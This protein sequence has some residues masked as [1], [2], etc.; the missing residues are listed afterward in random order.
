[1]DNLSTPAERPSEVAEKGK[2]GKKS[3]LSGGFF[4]EEIFRTALNPGFQPGGAEPDRKRINEQL[5]LN[6][7]S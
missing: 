5:P 4:P 7:G 3:S 1:M 2:R 6:P